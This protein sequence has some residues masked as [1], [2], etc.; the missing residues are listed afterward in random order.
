MGRRGI[1]IRRWFLVPLALVVVPFLFLA[2]PGYAVPDFVITEARLRHRK[3]EP[4]PDQRYLVRGAPVLPGNPT[5]EAIVISG[6]QISLGANCGPTAA[7]LVV[8]SRGTKVKATWSSCTGLQ[9]KVKLAAKIDPACVV[10]KGTIKARRL[11]LKRRFDAP[12]S[13]CGDIGAE[14][15]NAG[16][17]IAVNTTI[18]TLEDGLCSFQ[19]AVQAANT[20]AAVDACPAGAPGATNTIAFNIPGSGIHTI[21][22]TTVTEITSSLAIEGSTQP[23]Y[24]GVP[25]I[26]I[27]GAVEDLLFFNPNANASALRDLMLTN[28]NRGGL[29]DGATA[30]FAS[31]NNEITGNYFN[32]DGINSIGAHGAGLL[33][34]ISANNV[35]GGSTAAT[36]NIFGGQTGIYLQDS[37]HNRVE[38][39]YFGVRSDGNMPI[40]GLPVSGNGIQVFDVMGTPTGN[41]IRGN[42][43]TGFLAGVQLS[44]G[45]TASTVQGNHIGVGADGSTVHGN[46][47]GVLV[48]G[49]S[50]NTIGGPTTADRNV[51][52]G[53]TS[54]NIT[55]EAHGPYRANNNIIDGNYIGPDATGLNFVSPNALFGVY[56]VGG[57]AANVISGN[58]IGG[59]QQGIYIDATSGVASG[60]SQN[61]I[62]GNSIYGVNN[63]NTVS[64]PLADNWWGDGRGP[65][66]NGDPV[67]AGDWVSANVTFVPFLTSKP[68]RCTGA[69]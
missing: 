50:N 29:I 61:C 47:I 59:N 19:E 4:C 28:T 67:G 20:S 27:T 6:K 3:P 53:N 23:G 13:T 42:V 43:I 2:A 22:V 51:M 21:T 63:A 44:Q 9:G 25:L 14:Q 65:R 24:A 39:N 64:A 10:M 33:F 17:V 52:S 34:D 30:F 45:A 15:C 16:T 66:Y 18:N 26:H 57:A 40:S 60:S 11:R 5:P 7:K 49:A 69:S 35:I 68:A 48:Y 38:G 12:H 1:R 46:G 37:S 58:V 56:V 32:T 31:N 62:N 36:R 8:T 55:L 54:T 41:V